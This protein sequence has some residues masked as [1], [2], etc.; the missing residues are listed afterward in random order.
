ML[1]LSSHFDVRHL[2]VQIN[3]LIGKTD[4]LK[5]WAKRRFY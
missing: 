2:R 3:V 1:R 4:D 5:T